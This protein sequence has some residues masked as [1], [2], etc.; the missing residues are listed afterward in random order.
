MAKLSKVISTKRLDSYR[1]GDSDL[2]CL[3]R[4]VW[5]TLLSESLYPSIQ[6]LEVALRNSIHEAAKTNFSN[7]LWFDDAKLIKNTTT[8][9]IIQRARDSLTK[10]NKLIHADAIVAELSF[11]FWRQLFFNEYEKKFWRPII[12][13]VFP[14]APKRYRQR[15]YISP[16]IHQAKELRNRIFHH[17]P[18]WH[19]ANLEQQHQEILETIQWMSQPFYE[20]AQLTDRFQEIRTMD[21]ADYEDALKD[22]EV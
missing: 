11:G 22:L 4:Y 15:V 5:N 20:M 8:Q 3:K 16:R 13:D 21:L 19:W 12:K 1:K 7:D 9:K 18:V 2:E 10:K 17:E 14:N 6:H